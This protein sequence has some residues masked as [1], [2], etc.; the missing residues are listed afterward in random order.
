MK[1]VGF[2]RRIKLEWL[3]KVVEFYKN[4]KDVKKIKDELDAFLVDQ[5]KSKVNR[6]KSIDVL[7]SSWVD[8]PEEFKYLRDKAVVLFDKVSEGEKSLFIGL[9][10]YQL[11][12]YL[13]ILALL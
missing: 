10:L 2:A 6:G 13:V 3:D 9:C 4:E 8:V 7:I 5:V 12:L 1:K 11:F